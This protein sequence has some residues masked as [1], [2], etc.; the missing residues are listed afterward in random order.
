MNIYIFHHCPLV[1]CFN[2][3]QSM[4][5]LELSVLNSTFES[6]YRMI[7]ES[8]GNC[9]TVYHCGLLTFQKN[10]SKGHLNPWVEMYLHPLLLIICCSEFWL[11]NDLGEIFIKF[12]FSTFWIF[13]IS[14]LVIWVNI[15]SYILSIIDNCHE[16]VLLFDKCHVKVIIS[17]D[18]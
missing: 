4:L 11:R 3:V 2:T 6:L 14:F 17:W 7:A 16:N 13:H 18:L 9:Y 5:L 12:N 8:L 1:I 15:I 10:V